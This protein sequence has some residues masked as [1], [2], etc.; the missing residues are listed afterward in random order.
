MTYIPQPQVKEGTITK[1][2][3]TDENI[4]GL[5]EELIKQQKITNLHLSL[6]TDTQIRKQEVE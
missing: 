4:I 6:V 5:L 3:V 1:V 2:N